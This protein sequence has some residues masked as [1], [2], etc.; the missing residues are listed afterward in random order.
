MPDPGVVLQGRIEIQEILGKG[1]YGKVYKAH[2]RGLDRIVAV[3]ELIHRSDVSFVNSFEKEAQMLAQLEHPALPRVF[4]F[5]CESEGFYYIMDYIPGEDLGA[6]VQRQPA[7]CVDEETALRIIHPV[8]D[9]LDYLHRQTP[10][11]IHRDVKHAN[12]RI[13]EEGTI[14]LVDFGIA[15]VY[16]PTTQTATTAKAVTPGFSPLEQYRG[17]G[18]TDPRT[19]LYSVGATLYYMLSGIIPTD[20]VARVQ[21]SDQDPLEPLSSINPTV[22]AY[23]E[24]IIHRL[25]AMQPEQRYQDVQS[26]KYALTQ[27]Q[28]P[29]I[30][31]GKVNQMKDMRSIADLRAE[32]EQ[33]I[34]KRQQQSDTSILDHIIW[35]GLQ[36]TYD[37][38]CTIERI[39]SKQKYDLVFIGKIGTGKT[40]AI[41]HLLDLLQ[42]AKLQRKIGEKTRS[43]DVVRELFS[44]GSGRTTIGEVVITPASTTYIEMEPY[45]KEELVELIREFCWYT[46]TRA[47]KELLDEE[48]SSDGLST[49]IDRAIRNITGLTFQRSDEQSSPVEDD[50]GN[51]EDELDKENANDEEDKPNN[52]EKGSGNPKS[53]RTDLAVDKARQFAIDQFDSFFE[54]VVELANLDH[55]VTTR[56]DYSAETENAGDEK[57]WLRKTFG[58]INLGKLHDFSI[59]KRICVY[60]SPAIF[61]LSDYPRIGS[62]IDTRGVA[63]D[64]SREDL[65]QYIRH[66]EDTL[67]IFTD[68]FPQA[69]ATIADLMQRYLIA[70]AHDLHSKSMLMVL[71]KKGEPEK[72]QDADGIVGDVRLG[73]EEK[74]RNIEQE[75][76]SSQIKLPT[77]HVLFYDALQFYDEHQRFNSLDYEQEDVEDR[78]HQVLQNILDILENR[79]SILWDEVQA[80]EQRYYDIKKGR[81]L[82]PKDI[83]LINHVKEEIK[84]YRYQNFVVTDFTTRYMNSWM[85]RHAM[86]LRATNNRYGIYSDINIYTA[87]K[88]LVERLV[89]DILQRPKNNVYQAIERISKSATPEANLQPFISSFLTQIDAYYKDLIVKVGEEMASVLKEDVFAPQS[90][91]SDFWY[92]VIDRWGKGKGYKQDVIALYE[93]QLEVKQITDRLQEIAEKRWRELFLD[94]VLKFFGN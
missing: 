2:H 61:D 28:G 86:R 62:V 70:E 73:I 90:S 58:A 94:R 68:L 47:Y 85:P 15:K 35:T 75:L 52:A 83:E 33:T 45:D 42:E 20:V 9:A 81:G 48:T 76:V 91:G 51:P 30:G 57:E 60:I 74:M 1:G 29:D 27:K 34:E 14:Y 41:C 72:V 24:A 54:A 17:G 79:E 7:H 3:K 38:L 82:D 56:A 25:L 13:T 89:L 37:R 16:D 10:P 63:L 31:P 80:L 66:R 21:S 44:T 26:L 84:G 78:R 23:L 93:H 59:P 5:F 50:M 67:C 69:P 64:I 39:L 22:P 55:R 4:D 88:P 8:L 12:I 71:Y 36:A 77:E 6:Y 46:W 92:G 11:V 87:T 40:T 19:D 49:E 32:M 53:S 18:T 43:V 65:E